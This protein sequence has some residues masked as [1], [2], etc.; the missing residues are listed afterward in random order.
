MSRPKCCPGSTAPVGFAATEQDS[1]EPANCLAV[2]KF[3]LMWLISSLPSTL[4]Q[5]WRVKLQIKA[6]SLPSLCYI[7]KGFMSLT[8]CHPLFLS[9]DPSPWE[10]EKA[11]TQSRLL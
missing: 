2:D 9:C 7:K 4:P 1:R 6:D 10:V 5:F 8:T 11:V 3:L